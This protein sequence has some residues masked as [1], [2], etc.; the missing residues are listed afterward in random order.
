MENTDSTPT[1][2]GTRAIKTIVPAVLGLLVL[3][4]GA[5]LLNS[6][7]DTPQTGAVLPGVE[8]L[9]ETELETEHGLRVR[10]IGVTAGG[11]MIDFRLKITDPEKA[12]MFLTEPEN[13]P[14]LV[15]ADS[16]KALTGTEELDETTTW[17]EGGILFILFSNSGGLIQ[18]GRPV[19][20]QFGDVQLEPISAQ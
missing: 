13:L 3:V 6:V 4:L 11:G 12:R 18:P 20:V 10:L 17:R 15:A 5:Y 8:V 16:G 9:T 7:W 2:G 19:I 14:K 1:R